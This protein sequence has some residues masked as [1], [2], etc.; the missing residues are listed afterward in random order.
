MSSVLPGAMLGVQGDSLPGICP[1]LSP[2]SSQANSRGAFYLQQAV[3]PNHHV[4]RVEDH[5]F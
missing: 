1:A 2:L 3:L 4:I 5:S